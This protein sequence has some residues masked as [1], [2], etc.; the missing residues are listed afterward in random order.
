M[1]KLASMENDTLNTAVDVSQLMHEHPLLGM[2]I[3]L[4]IALVGLYL[5]EKTFKRKRF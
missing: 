5:K 2:W 4:G 1:S 3:V